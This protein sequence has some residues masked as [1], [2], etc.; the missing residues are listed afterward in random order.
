MQ[1]SVQQLEEWAQ[2]P[3]AERATLSA[4]YFCVLGVFLS[5]FQVDGVIELDEISFV[6]LFIP[7]WCQIWSFHLEH[8]TV[9]L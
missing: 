6:C 5:V 7:P 4:D 1:W 3:A 2:R 9:F 8:T